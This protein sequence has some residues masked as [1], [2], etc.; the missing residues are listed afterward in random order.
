MSS[1]ALKAYQRKWQRKPAKSRGK[2]ILVNAQR[3]WRTW[4]ESATDRHVKAIAMP[5]FAVF[6]P[7]LG[8]GMQLDMM[9]SWVTSKRGS[10]VNFVEMTIPRM[11]YDKPQVYDL[12]RGLVQ[13]L[14]RYPRTRP[15]E[16]ACQLV[17]PDL[18]LDV[19]ND[20]IDAACAMSMNDLN[21]F[22]VAL[23]RECYDFEKQ[24]HQNM[25]FRLALLLLPDATTPLVELYPEGAFAQ[26]IE[27]PPLAEV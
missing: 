19:R 4:W 6:N 17:R 24:G 9:T 13:H 22:Q 23:I 26:V 5:R 18:N 7:V 15:L 25:L 3:L 14:S 21:P 8:P 1:K 27:V 11:R 2:R 20:S 16:N 10:V 12:F